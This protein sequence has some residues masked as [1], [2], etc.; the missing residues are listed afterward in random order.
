MAVHPVTGLL[1]AAARSRREQ[2]LLALLSGVPRGPALNRGLALRWL[3]HFGGA[4]ALAALLL[5]GFTG[6][7]APEL[8]PVVLV[9]LTGLWPMASLL[10]TDL[11]RLSAD[12]GAK[13]GIAVGSYFV[14]PGLAAGAHLLLAWPLPAIVAGFALLTAGLLAWRWRALGSSP[15][16]FPACRLA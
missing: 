4:W 11:L 14:L 16:A 6:W 13:I 12:P 10:L 7:V 1:A 2:A 3:L 9:G 5:G 8:Q 15:A